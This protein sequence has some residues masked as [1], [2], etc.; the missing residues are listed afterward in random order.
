LFLY[1]GGIVPDPDGLITGGHD[2]ET[3]RTI[4]FYPGDKIKKRP[5]RA[6]SGRSS[7]TTERAA[8][9]GSRRPDE[10]SE[11]GGVS[12][13]QEPSPPYFSRRY[14]LATG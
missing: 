14:G 5:L 2:N 1:D 10:V 13:G 3:A 12:S 11:I 6:S 4:S 8:G 7:P 9:A